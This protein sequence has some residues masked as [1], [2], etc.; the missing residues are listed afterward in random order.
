MMQPLCSLSRSASHGQGGARRGRR[1]GGWLPTRVLPGSRK[2]NIPWEPPAPR[3][4]A[5]FKF[6]RALGHSKPPAA[7][8]SKSWVKTLLPGAG[9]N[10]LPSPRIFCSALTRGA[11]RLALLF[12]A[13][14]P[15]R[16]RHRAR[17]PARARPASSS[18]ARCAARRDNGVARGGRRRAGGRTQHTTTNIPGKRAGRRGQSTRL[19]GAECRVSARFQAMGVCF[20]VGGVEVKKPREG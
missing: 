17:P 9:G 10:E 1:L 8:P 16:R 2:C 3:R 13:R 4:R 5:P 11:R 14:A 18:S 20:R 15:L 7:A 19:S 6:S 12:L